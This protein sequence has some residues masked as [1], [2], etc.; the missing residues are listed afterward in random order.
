MNEKIYAVAIDGPG[1]AGKSS[2]ARKIAREL[3]IL[4]VDTGAIYRTVG[5]H[6]YL[7][8]QQPADA[9][10]VIALYE[11]VADITAGK[12]N[13][14]NYE[15]VKT[16]LAAA[17]DA[18][19]AANGEVQMLVDEA[20][21]VAKIERAV[22]RALEQYENEKD[23]PADPTDPQQPTDPSDPVDPA[24]PTDPEQPGDEGQGG[25]NPVVIIV[26]AV[27]VLAVVAVVIIV[28]K[29]KK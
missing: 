20:L 8:G 2:I 28:A 5:Y 19:N 7:R 18:Y 23:A 25:L 1:G 12:V 14:D 10:A 22:G 9:E 27:S 16:Q 24:D 3:G 13:A 11:A 26:I 4:Y 6:V 17:V 21:N 29:K 15:T